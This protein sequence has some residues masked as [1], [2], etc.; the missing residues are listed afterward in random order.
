VSPNLVY[1]NGQNLGNRAEAAG[2]GWKPNVCIE[3]K[4]PVLFGQS[5]YAV[6]D[7]GSVA[8]GFWVSIQFR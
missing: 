3:V 2:L 5:G 1:K 6:I 4:N 8:G 7:A